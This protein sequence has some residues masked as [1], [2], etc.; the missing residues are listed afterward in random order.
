VQ[1]FWNDPRMLMLEASSFPIPSF[2]VAMHKSTK[3]RLSYNMYQEPTKCT[4]HT[5]Y[6]LLH[7]IWNVWN[8]VKLSPCVMKACGDSGHLHGLTTYPLNRHL[9]ITLPLWP[10]FRIK[11][12]SLPTL[13]IEPTRC[14]NFSNL[15][16]NRTRNISDRFSVHHQESSTVHAATGVCI[17]V[18]TVLDSWWWRENLPKTCRVLF[19]N[20][21]EKLV[22]LVGSSWFYYKNISQWMVLWMSKYLLCPVHSLVPILQIPSWLIKT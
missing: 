3:H 12:S 21:F 11:L 5:L 15:L 14:T 19:Q 6:K 8:Q 16:W 1:N 17:A 7:G 9:D 18:C 22:H 20:K 2:H 4:S 10:F 13:I